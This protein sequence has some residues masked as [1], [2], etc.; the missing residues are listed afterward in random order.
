MPMAHES[1]LLADE[2]RA[3]LEAVEH[4]LGEDPAKAPQE[5]N[6]RDPAALGVLIRWIE[7]LA[8]EV[9]ELRTVVG[10]RGEDR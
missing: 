6:A 10:T 3:D 2:F 7:L 9:D 4:E 1:R 8:A 5:W